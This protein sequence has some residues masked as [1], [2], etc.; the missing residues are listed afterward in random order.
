MDLNL[1]EPSLDFNICSVSNVEAYLA[2]RSSIRIIPLKTLHP[3]PGVVV[4]RCVLVLLRNGFVTPVFIMQDG[5]LRKPPMIGGFFYKGS[6]KY[7]TP[8]FFSTYGL[9]QDDYEVVRLCEEFNSGDSSINCNLELPIEN[10]F[11]YDDR[12][13]DHIEL[14]DKTCSI[15]D[16]RLSYE[17]IPSQDQVC[18]LSKISTHNAIASRDNS[19]YL[20]PCTFEFNN[21]VKTIGFC[22]VRL[23]L[24]I[25][26]L[27]HFM[28]LKFSGKKEKLFKEV[29][30]IKP[31]IVSPVGKSDVV[32]TEGLRLKPTTQEEFN[33][34][35]N[36]V[37]K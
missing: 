19:E 3:I 7:N 23:D 28:D 24:G 36:P 16:L 18:F 21:N 33:V 4:G 30:A 17:M 27:V 13:I 22:F 5:L 10:A 29:T 25:A 15:T 34:L 1:S 11:A 9:N 14:I 20:M 2:G 26:S 6:F 37:E 12:K 32:V 8:E 35:G 31:L